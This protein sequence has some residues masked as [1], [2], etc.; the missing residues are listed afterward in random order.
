VET[1]TDNPVTLDQT[2]YDT[3][4][5]SSLDSLVEDSPPTSPNSDIDYFSIHE[6]S[7]HCKQQPSRKI[8]GKT[9]KGKIAGD[10]VRPLGTVSGDYDITV[11]Q[12]HEET[13]RDTATANERAGCSQRLTASREGNQFKIFSSGVRLTDRRVRTGVNITS[14]CQMPMDPDFNGKR[15]VHAPPDPQPTIRAD[16]V[17][18]A[19][20]TQTRS[21]PPRV[22]AGLINQETAAHAV[23]REQN[24]SKACTPKSGGKNEATKPIE[25]FLSA[26]TIGNQCLVHPNGHDGG[27]NTP[28]G[29]IKSL[30]SYAQGHLREGPKMRDEFKEAFFDMT[31]IGE[32]YSD[33]YC[34]IQEE[35]D[36][37]LT[38]LLQRSKVAYERKNYVETRHFLG[39]FVEIV[40]WGDRARST[41]WKWMVEPVKVHIARCFYRS[42]VMNE[43]WGMVNS[44]H[45]SPLMKGLVQFF[46]W[47]EKVS[48][49]SGRDGREQ[50]LRE[51][52]TEVRRYD[53][54]SSY[55]ANISWEEVNSAL[56]R[57]RRGVNSVTVPLQESQCSSV[58]LPAATASG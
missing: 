18:K 15:A 38:S 55:P 53:R 50:L 54:L 41:E 44:L 32:P 37:C 58:L 26:R 56:D 19:S 23:N 24:A 5:S 20:P 12:E 43:Y 21:K 42:E 57:E 34:L 52:V 13:D 33:W 11:H 3:E 39:V 7:N 8:I 2:Y 30:S 27:Y 35:Q 51:A 16:T 29:V 9:Q 49:M 40:D 22:T 48:A 47:E 6:E 4:S 25:A 28:Q 10:V 31:A 14:Q 1:I 46:K 45:K 17:P 36:K